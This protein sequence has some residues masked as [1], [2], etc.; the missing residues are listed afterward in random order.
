MVNRIPGFHVLMSASVL[1]LI[2]C[3]SE[4]GRPT[5]VEVERTRAELPEPAPPYE[6][7][8][9]LAAAFTA[10]DLSAMADQYADD[11]V[12]DIP[13][14]CEFFAVCGSTFP[15]TLD[16]ELQMFAN[17]MDRHSGQE[18]EIVPWH[19]RDE[20]RDRFT[21]AASFQFRLQRDDGSW[22]W[23][24][25]SFDVE[26]E[27]SPEGGHRISRVQ[28]YWMLRDDDGCGM[29]NFLCWYAGP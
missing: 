20:G 5:G 11:F 16:D 14:T 10:G 12:H 19:A 22:R 8:D 3:S 21:I 9:A 1:S 6:V 15:W 27:P 4:G 17:M 13:P 25:G 7:L 26:T 2:S 23:R 18:L 29:I 28:Q 24:S